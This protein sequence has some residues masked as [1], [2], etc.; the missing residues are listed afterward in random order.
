M[1]RLFIRFFGLT[2]RFVVRHKIAVIASWTLIAITCVFFMPSIGNAINSNDASLLPS[3]AP[4]VKALKLAKTFG[5]ENFSTVLV[6]VHQGGEPITARQEVYLTKVRSAI[7]HLSQVQN[8]VD[9]GASSDGQAHLFIV[10]SSASLFSSQN[11]ASLVEKLNSV[12]QRLSKGTSLQIDVAGEIADTVAA[13]IANQ[14]KANEVEDIST[15]LILLLLL[16]V[17]RSLLAPVL[18]FLPAAIAV[19]ISQRLVAEL[20]G[21]GIQ[22][23]DLTQ[24]LLIAL[25]LGAGTDYGLFLGL[26]VR[27]ELRKSIEFHDAIVIA[28]RRVGESIAFSALTVMFALL[29]LLLAKFGMYQSLG[30]PLALSVGVMLLAGLTL[31]PAL[32]ALIGPRMFWPSR[33]GGK[34]GVE[35]RVSQRNIW[36]K[37]AKRV[38]Q[39]PAITLLVGVAGFGSLAYLASYSK[40]AGTEGALSAPSNSTAYIGDQA[41]TKHW[42]GVSESPTAIVVKLRNSIWNNAADLDEIASKLAQ[43]KLFVST[44]GPL[45]PIGLPLTT[46]QLLSDH[47]ILG[48]ANQLA[49]IEP[50]NDYVAPLQYEMYQATSQF[51]SPDGRTIQFEASLSGGPP[52]STG[53]LR[54]IPKLRALVNEL[55]HKYGAVSTGVTG[56]TAAVYD[57]SVVSGSDFWRVVP[58]VILVI[59]LL[60]GLMLKSIVAPLYLVASVTL[61]LFATLGVAVIIFM[62]IKHQGGVFFILPFTLFIFLLALGEDYNIL[63]MSRIRDE[64]TKGNLREAIVRALGSTGSTISSAGLVMAGTFAVLAFSGD[65]GSSNAEV[66]QVGLILAIGIL[67]DTFLVRSILVPSVVA[68][69]GRWNWWPSKLSG[70]HVGR[71]EKYSHHLSDLT[72]THRQVHRPIDTPGRI[73]ILTASLGE[74]HNGVASEIARRLENLGFECAKVDFC[75]LLPMRLGNLIRFA[76]EKS[77]KY[78]PHTYNF[79]FRVWLMPEKVRF[80]PFSPIRKFTENAIRQWVH[81]NNPVAIVSTFNITSQVLGELRDKEIIEVPTASIL[82]DFFPHGAWLHKGID[83]NICLHPSVRKVLVERGCKETIVSGPTVRPIYLDPPWDRFVVRRGLGVSVTDKLVLVVGGSWGVGEV[84]DAL[85]DIAK[86]PAL[87]PV[88]VCGRNTKLQSEVE[89][90]VESIGRGIV[91]G[92]VRDLSPLMIACDA[93]LENAGGLTCMEAL[94]IGLP[95]VSYRP[96]PGHGRVNVQAM[97]KA[98]VVRYARTASELQRELGVITS[99]ERERLALFRQVALMF[100]DG[101]AASAIAKL[102]TTA[103]R[104]NAGVGLWAPGALRK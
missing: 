25:V 80:S 96:I 48:P 67:M 92:W 83:L 71:F 79:I 54:Q 5:A 24:I 30:I 20:P 32:L 97:A 34:Q 78:F 76:F 61:S 63:L 14:S 18:I 12:C 45:N 42:P 62:D 89:K 60:L 101:D 44:L 81:T 65:P 41:F 99:S 29:C 94:S 55:G 59:A 47:A 77:V 84:V 4:S 88:V 10:E 37:T 95:V 13:Q 26:R 46:T 11:T 56:Q 21:A 3:S 38:V 6:V 39:R 75:N 93:M 100:Q 87:I 7:A 35:Y 69:L 73:L 68:L 8:V 17:F 2:G 36:Y 49:N 43:S 28:I 72:Q 16:V 70:K 57:V 103:K 52:L 51:I 15:I 82:V 27:E 102:I 19:I 23:S 74:G 85:Q 66:E 98:G 9:A 58:V 22:I 90:T 86:N 50:K 53:A 33:V 91:F 104:R 64:S 31:T 40:P 1:R